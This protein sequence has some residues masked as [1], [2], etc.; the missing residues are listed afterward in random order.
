MIKSIEN[1]LYKD[2]L[3]MIMFDARSIVNARYSEDIYPDWLDEPY[4]QDALSLALLEDLSKRTE[5][6]NRI[7]DLKQ[8]DRDLISLILSGYFAIKERSAYLTA[9]S[10]DAGIEDLIRALKNSGPSLPKPIQQ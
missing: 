3:T 9:L 2:F 1:G 6:W 8:L 10:P 7:K 5:I 4:G